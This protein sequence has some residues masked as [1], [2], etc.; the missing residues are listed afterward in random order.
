MLFHN[1]I[2]CILE[3]DEVSL[4]PTLWGANSSTKLGL[5]NLEPQNIFIYI[6]NAWILFSFCW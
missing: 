1:N 3:S 4:K 5:S 6:Y 2:S